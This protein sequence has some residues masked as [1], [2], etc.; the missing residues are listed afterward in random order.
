MGTPQT[1]ADL[2]F[3][4]QSKMASEKARSGGNIR[5]QIAQWEWTGSPARFHSPLF[6]E[7]LMWK[8]TRNKKRERKNIEKKKNLFI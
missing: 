3:I 1:A 2:C 4:R 7:E 6:A 5:Q 8:K